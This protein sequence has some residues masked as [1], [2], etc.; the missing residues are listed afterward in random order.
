MTPEL[1][2]QQDAKSFDDPTKR[3]EATKTPEV[4]RGWDQPRHPELMGEGAHRQESETG[5]T[6]G[7]VRAEARRLDDRV[8]GDPGNAPAAGSED[9]GRSDVG[10]KRVYMVKRTLVERCFYDPDTIRQEFG[11]PIPGESFDDFVVRVFE[12][13]EH[14]RGRSVCL[15]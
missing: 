13:F 12:R 11:Q 4:R 6:T 15:P 9:A 10:R 3:A 1:Q 5:A 8:G 14:S 2:G 7:G